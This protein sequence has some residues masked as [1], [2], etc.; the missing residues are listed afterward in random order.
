MVRV[1]KPGASLVIHESTWRKPLSPSE[2]QDFSERYGTTPLEF[3][4][5]MVMLQRAGF[6]EIVTEF[7]EW[8]KPEMFWQVRRNRQVS[9]YSQV[10]TW[11]EEIRTTL[12]I[13]RHYG[14]GGIVK[15]FTNRR[16]VF[17]TIM[18]EKLGYCLFKGVKQ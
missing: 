4:E 5:W 1:A 14:F 16:I 9:H 8:S 12:R 10:L 2:K 13:L 11:T 6:R 18:E 17:Q 7:E 3:D 15:A